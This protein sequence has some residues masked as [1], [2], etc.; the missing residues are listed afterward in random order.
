MPHNEGYYHAAYIIA[1]TVYGLYAAS[2]WVRRRSIGRRRRAS[3][4][5]R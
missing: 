5:G 2:V 3:G 4:E 1:V